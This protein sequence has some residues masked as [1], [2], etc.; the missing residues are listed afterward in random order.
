MTRLLRLLVFGLLLIATGATVSACGYEEKK[1]TIEGAIHENAESIPGVTAVNAHVNANTSG[2]F[3][4][5]KITADSSDEDE[6][7]SIA[8]GALTKILKDPRIEDGTLAMGVFS[9]DGSINIGPSDIG[10]TTST[11][12]LSSLRACFA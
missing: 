3:I 4:T 7:K 10:C 5:L 11:G 2:T 8:K 1:A 9:P 12:T 6:L